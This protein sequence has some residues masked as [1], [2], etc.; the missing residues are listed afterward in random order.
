MARST[1]AQNPRG[2]AKR[3]WMPEEAAGALDDVAVGVSISIYSSVSFCASGA[4]T[5]M[6]AARK[7]ISFPASG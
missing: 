2:L 7:T 3:T 6:T 4:N 5:E 1:P